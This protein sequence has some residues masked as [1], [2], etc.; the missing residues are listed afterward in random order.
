[1]AD[2]TRGLAFVGLARRERGEGRARVISV[3]DHPSVSK[4]S[5]APAC[6]ELGLSPADVTRSSP[7]AVD[8]DDG[9]AAFMVR[10]LPVKISSPFGRTAELRPG[11]DRAHQPQGHGAGRRRRPARSAQLVYEWT[12]WEPQGNAKLYSAAIFMQNPL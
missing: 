11:A 10:G 8:G 3:T 2:D 7:R 1:M 12:S 9:E 5:E 6:F 4:Q